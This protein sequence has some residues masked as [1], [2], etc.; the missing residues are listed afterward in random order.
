MW[1]IAVVDDERQV[2][3]GM[4]RII[5]W[6]ELNAKPAGEAS[7][8]EEGLKLILE[9]QPD[10]VITDIY[11]PVKNGLDMIEEL[12]REQYDGKIIILSGYAD[13]E[14]ARQAM[15]LNVDDYL[16]KPV[17]VQTLKDVLG[18]A[19]GKLEEE[20]KKALQEGERQRKLTLYEPIAKQ[21]RLKA[22]VT[23]APGFGGASWTYDDGEGDGAGR[24]YRVAAV[25]ISQSGRL[26]GMKP[27][28][29]HLFRFAVA[30]IAAE[31]AAELRLDVQP[32]ELYGRQTVMLLRFPA[33]MTVD[34]SRRQ[35]VQFA[36]R[37]IQA[38]DAY[39]HIRIQVGIGGMKEETK[40]I[41]DSTEEAFQALHTKLC[42]PDE[43]FPIFIYKRKQDAAGNKVAELR[44]I[45]HYHE[46]AQALAGL[47]QHL[48]AEAVERL[49][50]LLRDWPELTAAELQRVAREVWTI[51]KYTLHETGRGLE[52]AFPAESVERELA[53]LLLP[54]QFREWALA[55]IEAVCAKFSRGDNLRHRQ[56]VDY[57]VRYVHEHYAEDLRL[58]DLAEQVYISRSYLSNIFR[59]L[60]GE[61]FN[62]YVT[63]VRMEKAR[64]M[65]AE[66]KL[67]VYE[68]AEKVGYKNVPYFTTL[69][70]K[71]TGRSPTE[72]VKN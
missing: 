68:I 51:C 50:A 59:D 42:V 17:T 21:E 12:R 60:A 67:M 48:A 54:A 41:A 10:I 57:M 52:E 45:R 7:D 25:E 19:I 13:F 4:R 61:T 43:A 47:Q 2:L 24:Q 15:R 26:D 11:M 36:R 40:V 70:K 71:H 53:E 32:V 66:G 44:P 64:S 34:E 18:K 22:L 37:L 5:P 65:L 62:D 35:A 28:D 1:T 14:Y 30:N 63:K 29:W 9:Q 20:R 58:A 31:L 23:G 27:A 49:A 39:L 3:Q 46:I 33:G 8:G 6:R 55:K 56:A 16:S 72:F 69:F 38:A